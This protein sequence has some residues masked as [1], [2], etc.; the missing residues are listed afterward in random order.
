MLHWCS[1]GRTGVSIFTFIYLAGVAL[2]QTAPK[3]KASPERWDAPDGRVRYA[4]AFVVDERLSA[5][6][7][8]AAF[9]S[10]VRQRLRLG[11]QLYILER[12]GPRN[13]R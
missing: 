13:D 8:E 1:R 12:R 11:R 7:R 4:K 2:A 9:K 5:L 10:E 6:R 3:D